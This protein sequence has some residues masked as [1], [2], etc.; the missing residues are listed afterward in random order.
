VFENLETAKYAIM[1]FL[2]I[3]DQMEESVYT[4]KNKCSPEEDKEFRR[5]VGHV[6]CEVFDRI[7]VPIS[8]RHPSLKPPGLE[9]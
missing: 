7:I 2:S 6:I 3:N 4:I 8:R 5:Q 9:T 1:V